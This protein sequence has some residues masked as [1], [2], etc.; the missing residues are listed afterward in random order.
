MHHS[1]FL[2]KP[3]G[4][5]FL[6]PLWVLGFKLKYTGLCDES[7]YQLSHLTQPG[8]VFNTGVVD[9]CN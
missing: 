9:H 4:A 3:Y 6:F 2:N 7:S 8:A 1:V 5:D